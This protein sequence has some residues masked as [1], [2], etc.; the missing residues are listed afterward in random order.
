MLWFFRRHGM[1][2]VRMMGR[3]IT[4]RKH[5]F[6]Q[7]CLHIAVMLEQYLYNLH[8]FPLFSVDISSIFCTIFNVDKF[9]QCVRENPI[10][11]EKD[12]RAVVSECKEEN[13]CFSIEENMYDT[14]V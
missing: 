7:E 13:I 1:Q 9:I 3:L 2:S 6:K 14:W 11:Y 5:S 4:A 12:Q 10:T 8:T